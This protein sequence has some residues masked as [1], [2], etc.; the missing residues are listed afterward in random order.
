MIAFV[1]GVSGINGKMRLMA[2]GS[3]ALYVRLIKAGSGAA[4][5]EVGGLRWLRA[6]TVLGWCFTGREQGT[7]T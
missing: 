1:L 4:S 6:S 2:Y 5:G 3:E 7:F